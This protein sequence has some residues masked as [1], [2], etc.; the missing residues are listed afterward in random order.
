MVGEFKN[1]PGGFDLLLVAVA[2]FT[3]W[4]EVWPIANLRSERAA[5]F[6]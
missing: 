2:K 5:E 3:K 4:I 6:I 1:T